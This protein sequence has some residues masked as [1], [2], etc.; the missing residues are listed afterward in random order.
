MRYARLRL[1]IGI[2]ALLFCVLAPFC[3]PSIFYYCGA[4]WI[5]R[6]SPKLWIVPTPLTETGTNRSPGSK[7]SYFG[8]E[9]EAPWRDFIKER[10]GA[11]TATVNFSSGDFFTISRGLDVLN[12]WK[13]EVT[14]RGSNVKSVFGDRPTS[15]N[16]SL[17]STILSMTPGDLRL[18]SSPHEL[19]T[20]SVFLEFKPL[21]TRDRVGGSYS[22]QTNWLR[23]FQS[24]SPSQNAWVF[25]KA[26]DKQDH[27]VDLE[28]GGP[29]NSTGRISQSEINRILFTLQ[30]VAVA[31]PK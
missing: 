15:S 27:A 21:M 17:C 2:I 22:F 4:R 23:G 12:T 14:R 29:P 30:P 8:Y 3:G 11:L 1:P 26:F 7:Y 16:Y 20:N 24:G 10:P 28:I 13:E 25:I 19:N 18:F 5:F 6:N 9:F 31:A